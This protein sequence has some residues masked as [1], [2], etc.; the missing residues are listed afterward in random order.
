MHGLRCVL[1]LLLVA[2]AKPGPV[3][4]R[5]LAPPLS[6]VEL[7]L[8]GGA[9]MELRVRPLAPHVRP[10]LHVWDPQARR[11]AGRAAASLLRS[12]A[13]LRLHNPGAEARGYQLLLG[14]ESAEQ[15]GPVAVYRDGVQLAEATHAGAATLALA[16]R[17]V[18]RYQ[19]AAAAGGVRRALLLGFG[20]DGELLALD[21]RSGPTGLPLLAARDGIARL[22]VAALETAAGRISVYANDA[23]D[24]DGDGLG[25]R[26][27]RALGSCDAPGDAACSS[28]ALAAYYQKVEH[29]TRDSDRDGLPDA[30]ELF[31]VNAARLDLPRYGCDLRHKDVLVELDHHK[32]LDD[33]GFT[34][35]ELAQVAGLFAAGSASD[36]RN[37]DGRAGVRVHFD[38]GMAPRDPAHIG[39]FGDFGGSGRS[40]AN[41]YRSARRADF[42]PERAGYFRYAFVTRSGR[43]QAS[44]DA[45]TV[46]RDLQRVSILAHELGHTLGLAHHGHDRWGKANCKPS[47]YS[48]MNY[49]YQA[50]VELGFSQRAGPRQSPAR[51]RERAAAPNGKV[52]LL[53]DT[54]LELDVRGRDV[55]WNRDGVI[56]DEPVRAGLTW[57]TFKSCGAAEQA[58]ITLAAAPGASAT[59]LLVRSGEQLHALW[60]D[61][62]SQPWLQTQSAADLRLWSEPA[63]LDPAA[64]PGARHP[65]SRAGSGAAQGPA[66]APGAAVS[67]AR[68]PDHRAGFAAER[69]GGAGPDPESVAR[70]VGGLGAAPS[71]AVPMDESEFVAEESA[72][73]VSGAGPLTVGLAA[74]SLGGQRVALASVDELGGLTLHTV[75]VAG[76]AA[77]LQAADAGARALETP[78]LAW[79]DVAQERYGAARLL[80]I[81][82]RTGDAG[83]LQ[84]WTARADGPQLARGAVVDLDGRPLRAGR[85]PSLLALPTGELC[86]VFPDVDGFIRIYVYRPELDAWQ[87]LSADA[88]DA[89]LGP[90]TSG[91]VGLAFHLYRAPDGSPLHG[92]ATRGALYLSFTEPESPAARA[93]D[94]PHLY[95]S[96]WLDARHPAR[97]QLHMR[98]RGRLLTEWTN[99]APGT[100]TALFEDESSEALA[101]LMLVETRDGRKLELLPYA[102]GTHPAE[103]A[104]GSDFQVMERGICSVLRG[105]VVC[106]DA[107]TGAY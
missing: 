79:A 76:G 14:A 93:P 43:G 65:K 106:G 55:D 23:T 9:S 71:S 68:H 34:P 53:A 17:G 104:S 21:E 29:A 19:A 74:T 16:T 66:A 63:R 85:A 84:Q 20:A 33:I 97:R 70:A 25:R 18:A 80:M 38:A 4:E 22:S 39:V 30:D 59:P 73:S 49:L 31:G 95:V 99:L 52:N 51:V 92:D 2:C 75:D 89:A 40:S 7:S 24:R 58:S 101:A 32:K 37:P 72:R 88:F 87:D 54:P 91:P 100:G 47:Y 81:V 28:A 12:E 62:Q 86:G 90:R 13:A 35:E 56:S 57:G 44:G 94:N 96:E 61:G 60:L 98:W 10:Q 8:A 83:L 48:I 77:Q 64:H 46:N 26:L 67:G 11:E 1:C 5:V 42:T 6:R 45:L 105:D 27:E 3:A 50:R 69:G 41:E 82:A 36:L 107:S 15:S 103:L 78:A 102:D